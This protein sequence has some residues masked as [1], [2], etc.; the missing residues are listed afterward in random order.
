M[1]RNEAVQR[2]YTTDTDEPIGIYVLGPLKEH[3]DYIDHYGS[4]A[5]CASVGMDYALTDWPIVVK[6]KPSVSRV[7]LV[8]HLMDLAAAIN[9]HSMYIGPETISA[10]TPTL[11]T[12]SHDRPAPMHRDEVPLESDDW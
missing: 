11:G 5:M 4:T 12:V 2:G 3:F 8:G 6:V 1:T 10:H 7:E 9:Q